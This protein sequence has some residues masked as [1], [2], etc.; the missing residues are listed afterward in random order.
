MRR[1]EWCVVVLFAEERKK[2]RREIGYSAKKKL[3]ESEKEL[4]PDWK[5]PISIHLQVLGRAYDF[6]SFK[7]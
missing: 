5:E 3:K 6:W 2:E 1:L 4:L 7:W